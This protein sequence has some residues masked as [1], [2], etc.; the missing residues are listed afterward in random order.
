LIGEIKFCAGFYQRIVLLNVLNGV[1]FALER[2]FQPQKLA[3]DAWHRYR[4]E[5]VFQGGEPPVK[6]LSHSIL[7]TYMLNQDLAL[8]ATPSKPHPEL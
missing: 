8:L 2:V 6:L 5:R 7:H 4:V 1:R 3:V